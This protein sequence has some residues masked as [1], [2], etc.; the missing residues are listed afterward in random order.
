MEYAV[1]RDGTTLVTLHEGTDTTARAAAT[2]RLAES[3][4]AEAAFVDWSIDGASV[5]EGPTAP[6]DP[7]TV[8][9]EFG[10]TVLVEADDA[11]RAR[12]LGTAAIADALAAAGLEGVSYG[13]P[14]EATAA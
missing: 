2:D 1:S 14:A 5:Y 9:V 12:S 10:V 8:A 7:Y 4:E 6:F 11:G 3:L 13:S